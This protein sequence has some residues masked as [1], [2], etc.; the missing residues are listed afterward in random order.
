M[1]ARVWIRSKRKLLFGNIRFPLHICEYDSSKALLIT[2][3]EESKEKDCQIVSAKDSP[4][5]VYFGTDSEISE[6]DGFNVEIEVEE[7]DHQANSEG[8]STFSG[9]PIEN[10]QILCSSNV[11]G[12]LK[13]GHAK[14]A[15]SEII[16]LLN[17]LLG[18]HYELSS[19][20][21]DRVYLHPDETPPKSSYWKDSLRLYIPTN[22]GDDRLRF[23]FYQDKEFTIIYDGYPKAKYHLLLMPN[24][25]QMF[26]KCS[27]DELNRKNHYEMLCRMRDRAHWIIYK[28]N[29]NVEDFKIGFHSIPSLDYLHLHIIVNYFF[30]F[31]NPIS[32]NF[33]KSKDL[34]SKWMKTKKHM[35]SF[36]TS[37][38]RDV[39][40]VIEKLS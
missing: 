17:R 31:H 3:L 16:L 32:N 7:E 20:L 35:I 9:K 30:S 39:D 4:C 5:V 23:R 6:S 38:F 40:D 11:S 21:F 18:I 33:F 24:D 8:K 37:F 34:D 29:K 1:L 27:V 26:R 15:Q 2:Q 25:V 10:V 36:T 14:D 28:M 12:K 13:I 22:C 19:T